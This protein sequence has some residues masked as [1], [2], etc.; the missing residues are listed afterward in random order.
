MLKEISK[1]DAAIMLLDEYQADRIYFKDVERNEYCRVTDYRFIFEHK[2]NT[3]RN[4]I[5]FISAE[6]YEEITKEEQKADDVE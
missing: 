2:T 1:E 4:G 5:N 3:A 6:F